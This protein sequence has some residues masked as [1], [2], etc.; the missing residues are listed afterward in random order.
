LI[1]WFVFVADLAE[2]PGWGT[3]GAA[4]L[5]VAATAST[6]TEIWPLLLGILVV[7]L[8]VTS[9]K[10]RQAW[11]FALY[12]GGLA[13]APF[14]LLLGFAH[15]FIHISSRLDARGNW[16]IYPWAMQIE[17]LCR[18]WFGDLALHREETLQSLIRIGTVA[19]TFFGFWGLIDFT[20][21]QWRAR[22]APGEPSRGALVR[23]V[24]LCILG[25]ALVPVL[26]FL[27]DDRYPYQFYKMLL[28]TS[29]LLVV[30]ISLAC[31]AIFSAGAKPALPGM[32]SPALRWCAAI[33]VFSM[34]TILVMGLSGT[35]YMATRAITGRAADAVRSCYFRWLR[36]PDRTELASRLQTLHNTPLLIASPDTFTNSFLNA[37]TT[38]CARH[39]PL[40]LA[41][42]VINSIDPSLCPWLPKSFVPPPLPAHLH[43]VTGN[44]TGMKSTPPGGNAELLWSNSSFQLWRTRNRQWAVPLYLV[45]PY[46]AE[47]EIPAPF[48][49][50]GEVAATLEV[51]AGGP[52][53][54][55]L[56]AKFCLDSRCHP[57]CMPRIEVC[58]N[59][60]HRVVLKMQK[61]E[62]AITVPVPGGRTTIT[63]KT[64]DQPAPEVFPDGDNE[65]LRVAVR[66][67]RMHF[68]GEKVHGL[69]T[70]NKLAPE[71]TRCPQWREVLRLPVFNGEARTEAKN[72]F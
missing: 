65:I 37:W 69:V 46:G 6:Y 38:Y 42:P 30:G 47:P 67:L 66:G 17:G 51:M 34:G 4:A 49:W 28:S 5:F 55:T 26:I 41:N 15:T 45:Q 18:L 44:I 20:R 24:S 12:G 53:S 40:W 22:P 8:G 2:R 57:L 59:H 72:A 68:T 31:Q 62:Q 71:S 25:L 13:T 1:S 32:K 64:L 36:D 70:G 58:S 9:W 39:N 11:K 43:L 50:I 54:L 35:A 14:V 33:P 48:F 29:P 19:A 56:N 27:K 10:K 61:G 23:A 60:G 7:I 16:K 63:L 21:R 3:F 52:G